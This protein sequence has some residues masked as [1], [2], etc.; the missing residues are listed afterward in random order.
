MNHSKLQANIVAPRSRFYQ[1]SYGRICAEL[2]P[3]VPAGVAEDQLE[4][5]FLDFANEAMVE[6]PGHSPSEIAND[7]GLREALDAQFDSTIPAGYTY[8]GQFIDHDITLDVTP[9][10][11]ADVDPEKLHNFRT[12]RLDLDCVYGRGPEDQPYLFEHDSTGKMTGHMLIGK[13]EG[14]EFPDLLRNSAGR[15]IIGDKRNDENAIVAQIQLAF[16][17]AHNELV[18]RAGELGFA[19]SGE[20]AFKQARATLCRLYQWI[21]WHDFLKRITDSQI[22]ECAMQRD[23]G[24]GGRSIWRQGLDDIYKWRNQPFMPVEFSVAAYR[25]G[26][27]MVRNSYQTNSSATAGAGFGT[28]I[29]LID[30][31]ASNDDDL[32]GFRPLAAKRMVQWDWFL[33]MLSSSGPF[34]QMARKIDTRLS[35]ALTHLRE[36]LVNPGSIKN[37]LAAR[38]LVRSVRMGLPSGRDVAKKFGV[39]PVSLDEDEPQALWYY[40]LKEAEVLVNGNAGQRLGTVGSLI[41]CATFAGLLKGDPLSWINIEPD[42]TPDQDPLLEQND[43]QDPGDWTLASIIRISG[44]PVNGENF[45]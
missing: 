39:A 3:W 33:Q 29:P 22:H 12:P 9:L 42:W 26:H 31:T 37:V 43:N 24:C 8:F 23:V 19:Q 14:T 21:V 36:D 4:S 38:N 40:I 27:S 17:L 34:P 30:I 45:E 16:I 32:S 11:D 25:F 6:A 1:G 20:E 28:F 41:L 7:S 10:S 15:A 13:V 44:L 2:S 35:N 5:H 18:H